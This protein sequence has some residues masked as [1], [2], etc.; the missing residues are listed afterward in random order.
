LGVRGGAPKQHWL[1]V[2][3]QLYGPTTWLV[4]LRHVTR[5]LPVAETALPAERAVKARTVTRRK[6][7]S[8]VFINPPNGFAVLQNASI[9]QVLPE[10][11]GEPLDHRI[12]AE[13]PKVSILDLPRESGA[14]QPRSSL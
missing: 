3:V 14:R 4:L 2:E 1:Y 8:G 7:R 11:P 5:Q 9:G 13:R 10:G 6:A 12:A